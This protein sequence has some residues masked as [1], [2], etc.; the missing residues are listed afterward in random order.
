MNGW[1]T[2]LKLMLYEQERSNRPPLN[3]ELDLVIV[4]KVTYDWA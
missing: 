1:V 4:K 2:R 3:N